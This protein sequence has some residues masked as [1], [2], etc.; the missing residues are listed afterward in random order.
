DRY[1]CYQN[2]HAPDLD[3]ERGRIWR[4]VYIGDE[5]GKQ[6]SINP[7]GDLSKLNDE[8][9]VDLLSHPNIWQRRVAQ[10]LLSERKTKA[11]DQLLALLQNGKSLEYRLAALWTLY[12]SGNLTEETLES[13]STDKEAPIR[14]WS[15]RFTGERG[16]AGKE[17]I[18]RLYRLAMDP[19]P[20]VRSF[21]AYAARRLA[22]PATAPIVDALLRRPDADKDPILPFMIWMAAEA[23]IA[24][25]P[26]ILPEYMGAESPARSQFTRKAFHRI[27][28]TRDPQK[29]DQAMELLD[30][31]ALRPALLA[32][33][34]DG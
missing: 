28:D 31:S 33:A 6:I 2:A 34:I 16:E 26:R 22:T 20:I 12:T 24:N 17:R 32:A 15:A 1:P 9:L 25:D 23:N 21:V 3:R 13:T 7:T 27:A 11:K 5:K 8:Q 14:A 4:V 30:H 19:D 10:R 29:L 18:R